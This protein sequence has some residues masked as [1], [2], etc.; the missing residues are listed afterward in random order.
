M[1]TTPTT[2]FGVV[3]FMPVE[4]FQDPNRGLDKDSRTD[5]ILED[6]LADE[7]RPQSVSDWPRIHTAIKRG[8]LFVIEASTPTFSAL[9]R[10]NPQSFDDGD[11]QIHHS[12]RGGIDR[13][14]IEKVTPVKADELNSRVSMLKPFAERFAIVTVGNE[15]PYSRMMWLVGLNN[16]RIADETEV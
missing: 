15:R 7:P 8:N 16:F 11:Y 12:P 13:G 9:L 4:S 2:N 1:P 3:R 14:R 6:L 10:F 5:R